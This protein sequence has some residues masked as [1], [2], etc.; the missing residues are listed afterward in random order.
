MITV[1]DVQ[2][3]HRTLIENFGGSHGIRGLAALESAL[4]RAFQTFDDKASP[5]NKYEF[6][7]DIATGT[8]KYD[9]IVIWLKAN[10]G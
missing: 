4:A 6:I 10:T 5:G 7:I 1:E 2:Q 8:L 3:V 9:Q